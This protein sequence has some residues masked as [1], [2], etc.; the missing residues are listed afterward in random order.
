MK[1]RWFDRLLLVIVSLLL[2]AQAVG[3]GLLALGMGRDV[4]DYWTELML[5]H[6][7]NRVILC[8]VA[9]LLLIIGLRLLFLR[10]R[11][12]RVPSTIFMQSTDA[13]SIRITI[14]AIEA[15]ILRSSRS[16]T[17]VRDLKSRVIPLEN[18]QMK[19]ALQVML[20][21][22]ANVKEVSAA[23]QSA[24]KTA[25]EENTGIPVAEV[26]VVIEAAPAQSNLPARVE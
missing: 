12:A 5:Y 14:A 11:R 23:L 16:I 10:G 25:L 26:E 15:I 13:G 2:I 20:M 24:V 8:V 7:V 21:P 4:L 6:T 18:H 17:Q 3:I 22:D 9:V 1:I 19:V